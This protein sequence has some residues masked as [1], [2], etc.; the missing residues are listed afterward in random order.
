MRRFLVFFWAMSAV[1][2]AIEANEAQFEAVGES[3]KLDTPINIVSTTNF[4]DKET[5]YTHKQLF[6]CSPF[7][8]AIYKIKSQNHIVMLP[9]KPLQSSTR[10]TCTSNPQYISKIGS[11]EYQSAGF[12][13]VDINYY[14]SSNFVR[15]EFNAPVEGQSLSKSIEISKLN[16]LS[17]SKLNY[18]VIYQ[19]KNTLVL[20]I[21]ED[22]GYRFEIKILP[23]LK[24]L[25]GSPLTQEITKIISKDGEEER[26]ELDKTLQAM[27]ILDKPRI[28]ALDGGKFALRLYFDDTIAQENLKRFVKVLE[29]VDYSIGE[30]E[31]IYYD[32]REESNISSS[33]SIDI[34]SDDIKP[35]R[36]YGVIYNKGLKHYQELKENVSYRIESG[37]MKKSISFG[38]DK[39]YLS[40]VGE[41]GFTSVNMD[42]ATLV[43]EQ[44]TTDNYR[45]FVNYNE[46]DRDKVSAYTQEILSKEL[47]LNNPKNEPIL[48][49]FKVQDLM[50]NLSN[51]VY[52]ITLNYEEK[53]DNGKVV[54]SSRSKVVFVSDMGIG[55]NVGVDQAFVSLVSLSNATPIEGAD[56]KLYSKNNTLI[57]E[58]TSDASGVVQIDQK[59][60]LDKNPNM[61]IVRKGD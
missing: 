34:L 51:G 38:E 8:D 59:G 35:N 22:V 49:K 58:A 39:P 52:K 25:D 13:A 15:I 40:N 11:F 33:Y 19:E 61:I 20:Q 50:G 30:W 6:E 29:F 14:K 48:H 24:A 3:M 41:I 53:L 46:L 43:V 55:V 26:V 37:D 23:T 57:A 31:Y 7:V 47:I 54:D 56:V 17:K 18:S 36:S 44:V 21:N 32:D 1:L 5:T 4:I 16:N 60:L 12:T 27:E 28:V 9:Q 2:F 42:K 10:Y 45:Y